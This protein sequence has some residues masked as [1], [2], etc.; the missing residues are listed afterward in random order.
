MADDSNTLLSMGDPGMSSMDMLFGNKGDSA[1]TARMLA[2]S[3][4]KIAGEQWNMYKQVFAP[5][6][7]ELVAAHR[8]IIPKQT[9]LDLA[10]IRAQEA[11]VSGRMP[12]NEEIRQQQMRSLQRSEPVEQ[13]FYDEAMQGINLEDR[14]NAAGADVQQ[15]YDATK[16]QMQRDMSRMGMSPDSGRFTDAMAKMSYSRAKDIA[17][18]RTNARRAGQTENLGRLGMAMGTRGNIAG[19]TAQTGGAATN[20]LGQGMAGIGLQKAGQSLEGY[21]GATASNAQAAQMQAGQTQSAV[22]GA[23]ALIGA[24]SD[25]RL[26]TSIVRIGTRNNMPW[27]VWLWNGLAKDKFGLEGAEIGHMASEVEVKHPELIALVDGYKTV[28]YRGLTNG[29]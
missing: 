18:A 27:Y 4:T 5:Y 25:E 7:A 26:K 14:M 20:P 13:A 29:K 3:Q 19:L 6:E 8:S 23:S 16:P 17:F 12:I 21:A 22:S 1:D 24:F 2:E 10:R 9:G 28:N 15:A 11:D